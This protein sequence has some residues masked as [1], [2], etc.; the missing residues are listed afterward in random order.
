MGRTTRRAR[1]LGVLV[2]MVAVA[3]CFVAQWDDGPVVPSVDEEA[4]TVGMSAGPDDPVL[5]YRR[6]NATITDQGYDI[7]V[8]GSDLYTAGW[9]APDGIG[10][11]LLVTKWTTDGAYEWRAELD[12]LSTSEALDGEEMGYEAWC[13][14][15]GYVYVGGSG[16]ALARVSATGTITSLNV[17]NYDRLTDIDV[18][19]G[20]IYAGGGRESGYGGTEDEGY[21]KKF[22]LNGT[23]VWK[24]VYQAIPNW[25]ADVR[26]VEVDGD[27]IRGI[28]T[29]TSPEADCSYLLAWNATTGDV[30]SNASLGDVQLVEMQRVGSVIYA[31]GYNDTL[32]RAMLIKMWANG[33][34]IWKR[35][36]REQL[37][38]TK[39]R[40]L[41][42]VDD[43]IYA[44]GE[45]CHPDERQYEAYACKWSTDGT[46]LW[47]CTW[48]FGSIDYARG[49]AADASGVYITGRRPDAPYP[50]LYIVKLRRDGKIPAPAIGK[51]VS[52]APLSG[53]SISFTA[54][55][56]VGDGLGSI[57]WNFG[58]GT[59]STATNPVHAFATGGTFNVTLTVTDVDNSTAVASVLVAVVQDVAPGASFTASS[60]SP[61][62]GDA[63]R[64]DH[65]GTPGNGPATF[66]WTVGTGG[67]TSTL[68]N[69]TFTFAAAGT[70]NVTLVVTDADGDVGRASMLVIVSDEP[71]DPGPGLIVGTVIGAAAAVVLMIAWRS[72]K[73]RPSSRPSP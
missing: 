19:G 31:A 45:I 24:H 17:S 47:N 38:A 30:I 41:V 1:A 72:K 60:T 6:T 39:L 4:I 9:Y 16:T 12:Q 40:D 64:F 51:N 48:E 29:R 54:G 37:T 65:T 68:Q 11:G 7:I 50:D 44:C 73:L 26:D 59:N 15:S 8:N 3:T 28:Q 53:D 63:V 61:W 69:A 27:I 36:W 13:N 42:V 23:L 58:D 56:T 2:A 57:L 34:T 21:L 10:S 5:W 20:Y 52:G 18:A 33:T 67:P 43:A 66:L 35:M 14:G 62:T 55:G 49:I 32:G 71:V 25:E 46:H 70:Y 22:W